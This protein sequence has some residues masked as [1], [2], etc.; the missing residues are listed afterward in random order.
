MSS[1]HAPPFLILLCSTRDTFHL[2]TSPRWREQQ[3][4]QGRCLAGFLFFVLVHGCVAVAERRELEE[5]RGQHGG[6]VADRLFASGRF[7][8]PTRI[9]LCHGPRGSDGTAIPGRDACKEDDGDAG[10]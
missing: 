5:N 8:V 6:R 10:L 9:C 3:Q 7:L 2:Y 4:Q 1:P